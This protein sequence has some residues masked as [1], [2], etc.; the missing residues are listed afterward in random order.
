M[1][2]GG[3]GKRKKKVLIINLENGL[4]SKIQD[5]VAASTDLWRYNIK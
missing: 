4:S 2:N 1:L 5:N 3:S